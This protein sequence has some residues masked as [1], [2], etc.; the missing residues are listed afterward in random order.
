ML[1]FGPFGSDPSVRA[2]RGY[3]LKV[4]ILQTWLQGRQTASQPEQQHGI[5]FF[6]EMRVW[7]SAPL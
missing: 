1:I 5:D 3:G 7:K 2:N 6:A 4:L